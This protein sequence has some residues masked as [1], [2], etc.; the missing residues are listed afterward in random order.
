M[1]AMSA[2]TAIRAVRAVRAVTAIREVRAVR[3]VSARSRGATVAALALGS[4]AV[5]ACGARTGL[6]VPECETDGAACCRAAPEECN[7]EDDDCDGAIDDGLACFFLDGEPIDPIASRACGA[8]W[9][10]YDTPDLQ[11]ANP[12]PD[13]RRSGGVVIAVQ[14]GPCAGASL[15]LI[16][17]LPGDGSGGELE[18][19]FAIDPPSAGGLSV[20]DEP[21]EC[22]HHEATGEVICDFTWQPCCTDGVLLGTFTGDACVT[23]R[24]GSA[25]G[26]GPPVVL[27][28]PDREIA[29]SYDAP[30][31]ICMRIRPPAR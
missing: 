7:G 19:T 27:D 30:F 29:R 16:A 11:S 24:L 4:L 5:V 18:A 23:V 9:Y 25:V 17:D 10:S 28:G 15:A 20:A 21:S 3:A 1:S 8:A 31:E 22:V 12:V 13:I 6:A 2:V 26:V 14:H